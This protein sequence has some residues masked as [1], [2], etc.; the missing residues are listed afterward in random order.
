M[1]KIAFLGIGIVLL[2]LPFKRVKEE[3]SLLLGL[4]G[5]FLLFYCI[6]EKLKS[7][8]LNLKEM[9]QYLPVNASYLAILIKM[10]GITYVT[11]FSQDICKEAGYQTVA[12]QIGLAG[13]ITLIV[14]SIPIIQSLFSCIIGWWN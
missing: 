2:A 10:I 13:K 1:I 14:L 11:E 12:N 7:L 3:Y 4:A 9:E 6:V 8:L 5:S